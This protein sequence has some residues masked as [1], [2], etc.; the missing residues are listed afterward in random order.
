MIARLRSDDDAVFQEAW[1]DLA[2]VTT[3]DPSALA[4]AETIATEYG[5][6]LAGPG[7]REKRSRALVRLTWLANAGNKFAAGRVAAFEQNYDETKE[8]IARSAWWTRGEG[9]QPEGVA[10][11]LEDGGLLAENGD[12]PAMLDQAF[13][14]GHGRSLEHDRASAVEAYVKVLARAQGEDEATMRIKQSAA[15]G[16]LAML[17]AI[18]EQKDADAGRRVLP[19]LESKADSAQAGVHY[20][21][22]LM[23]ECVLEPANL[24]AA[25]QWYRKAATDPAWKRTADDKIRVIGTWCPGPA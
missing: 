1:R 16:L 13:A 3:R 10:R 15:R 22:G 6:A 21:L 9:Q 14:I 24:E 11:W 12:R 8:K 4:V 20:Y 7:A 2:R 25:R 23:N 19:A 5:A 17:N 18:V